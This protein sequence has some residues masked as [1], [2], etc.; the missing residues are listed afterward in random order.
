MSEVSKT[1][2]PIIFSQCVSTASRELSIPRSRTRSRDPVPAPHG[3]SRKCPGELGP[4]GN[5]TYRH[6]H[7]GVSIVMGVPPNERFIKGKSHLEMDDFRV[8]L[9]QEPPIWKWPS[10]VD[11]PTPVRLRPRMLKTKHFI[12]D[13]GYKMVLRQPP[14]RW[15]STA[16][17]R[18]PPP[19]RSMQ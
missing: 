14:S 5:L 13:I 19:S 16:I 17:D 11:L 8:P 3:M 15:C 4:S 6:D 18:F 9:F 12:E 1:S 10:I 7:L 2:H